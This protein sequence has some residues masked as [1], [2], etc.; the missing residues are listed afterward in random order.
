MVVNA[1][2]PWAVYEL[3]HPHYSSF[4]ALCAATAVPLLDN[5]YHLVRY[6]KLDGFA[7]FML[8]GFFLNLLMFAL[9]GD[10]KFLLIK[11]SLVTGLLGIVFLFSLVVFKPLIYYFALRFSSAGDEQARAAWQA[12]WKAKPYMRRVIRIMT[13]VWG[14]SLCL[15]SAIKIWLVYLVSIDVFLA[16][17]HLIMYG[18]IGLTIVWTIYYRKRAVQVLASKN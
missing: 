17:S 5:L 11:D 9:G 12:N 10:E 4:A 1:A 3:L 14:L 8:F 6:K 18:M 2:L 7:V 13:L 15:E 16:V